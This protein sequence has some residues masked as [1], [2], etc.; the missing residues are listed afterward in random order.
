MKS[1]T[2]YSSFMDASL[3][4]PAA[5]GTLRLCFHACRKQSR[6]AHGRGLSL[7]NGNSL[8]LDA[9]PGAAFPGEAVAHHA[10]ADARILFVRLR[11]IGE[12]EAIAAG[13]IGGLLQQVGD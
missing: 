10:L 5:N 4:E 11:A 3:P 9:L 7:W 2:R 6:Q 8:L 12:P 13:F 1:R